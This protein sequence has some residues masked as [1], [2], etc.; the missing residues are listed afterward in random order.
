FS[1][2]PMEPKFTVESSHCTAVNLVESI[3]AGCCGAAACS[4]LPHDNNTVAA[5]IKMRKERIMLSF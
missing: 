2:M 3:A 1:P 5:L 4:L